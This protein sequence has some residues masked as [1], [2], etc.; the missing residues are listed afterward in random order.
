MKVIIRVREGRRKYS[1][2]LTYGAE[3]LKKGLS[4]LG[5]YIAQMLAPRE[6]LVLQV[7][8]R[9][10]DGSPGVLLATITIKKVEEE[11]ER[12]K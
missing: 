10:I 4:I 11:E 9:K 7:R 5:A 6:G 12:E 1:M 2:P 8:Q 3:P